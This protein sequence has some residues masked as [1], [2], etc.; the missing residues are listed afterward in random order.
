MTEKLLVGKT[1]KNDDGKNVSRN[2]ANILVGNSILN[3]NGTLNRESA[4]FQ[5]VIDTMSYIR[6]QII[7]Q[8]F[9]KVAPA[10]YMPV[11]VGEGSWSEETVQNLVY[12]LTGSFFDGDVNSNA[13]GGRIPQVDAA[14]EPIRMP[15][16][17]WAKGTMW[18]IVEIEKASRGNWD[19]VES[20]LKTLRT[21][22]DLGIQEVAFLG[23][24]VNTAVTGLLTAA[25]VTSDLT[26]ITEPISGM[27]EAEF[28]AFIAGLL[29]RY[30]ANS[31]DTEMPDTFLIPTDDYLGLGTAASAT[32]PNISKFEYLQNT[33]K[34][35]TGNEAAKILPL[36][37]GQSTR[38][39]LG[40]ERYALYKDDPET[41]S[42][43]I[44]FDF[45]LLDVNTGDNFYFKQPSYG[46]Y[47]G[48]LVNR[49]A[50]MLYFDY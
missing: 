12:D 11:D 6:E 23:H 26:L 15:N 48:V 1:L 28:Q 31:G 36:S 33:F 16:V 29:A 14:L 41:L 25:D 17:T 34:K 50:E 21:N 3:A 7:G 45:N 42:M 19:I 49:P 30:Y 22:W 35:M 40:V 39:G 10:D 46:Q 13:A 43:N 2:H 27:T 8:K 4:A 44:P 5:Y 38:N 24:P 20:K 47:S 18:S 9:Y 32:Y 37:Y